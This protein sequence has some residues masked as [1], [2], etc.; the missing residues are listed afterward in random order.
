M[1]KKNFYLAQIGDQEQHV[2]IYDLPY[3]MFDAENP[4][5]IKKDVI[6]TNHNNTTNLDN[7]RII[8]SFDISKTKQSV[9]MPRYVSGAFI[10][11]GKPDLFDENFVFPDGVTEIDCAH[12]VKDLSYFIN[13][14]PNT[15][16]KIIVS[17]STLTSLQTDTELRAAAIS[18][19]QTYPD[20]QVINEKTSAKNLK[21]CLAQT[22]QK[23]TPQE[24]KQK[25]ITATIQEPVIL[26]KTSE[27]RDIKDIENV[28]NTNEFIISLNL[29]EGILNREIRKFMKEFDKQKRKNPAT[30]AQVTCIPAKN[31]DKLMEKVVSE[32][33]NKTEKEDNKNTP[34]A[35]ETK[36][37]KTV[38]KAEKKVL[39]TIKTKAYISNRLWKKLCGLCATDDTKRFV[40]ETINSVNLDPTKTDGEKLQ[41]I[42]DDQKVQSS[43]LKRNGGNCVV[44]GIDRL[45]KDRRRIIWTYFPKQRYFVCVD[46]V[47]EHFCNTGSNKAQIHYNNICEYA[48]KNQ[49]AKGHT[50]NIDDL[51]AYI[52][53]ADLLKEL[54][55]AKTEKEANVSKQKTST[56]TVP[57]KPAP[58]IPDANVLQNEETLSAEPVK[59]KRGRPRI[60]KPV[61]ELVSRG[62]RKKA[63]KESTDS[64]T[65]QS[66]ASEKI[67][68]KEA[69]AKILEN[70]PEEKPEVHVPQNEQPAAPVKK[71]RGRPRKNP[72]QPVVA[73]DSDKQTHENVA[74]FEEVKG[75]FEP[76][77]QIANEILV[78]SEPT[79]VKGDQ[80]AVLPKEPENITDI[81]P[82]EK[83]TNLADVNLLQAEIMS[84]IKT[85]DKT[86]QAGLKSVAQE[87]D[88]VKQLE[89]IDNI[90]ATLIQKEKLEKMLIEFEKTDAL[91]KKIQI[92]TNLHTK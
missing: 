73:S 77:E 46:V 18:F 16:R 22:Q 36:T 7:V 39:P 38:V 65:K 66:V 5:I 32:F 12:S 33:K 23:K 8:G 79:P 20:I 13:R 78:K 48:A 45:S 57:E 42:A 50:I 88:S 44:Q 84:F 51:S 62:Y 85:I 81:M 31:V 76:Q 4:L 43:Y 1:A 92:T 19:V 86:I 80:P 11:R 24:P 63:P 67:E 70:V 2:N 30:G 26:E 28:L 40:L 75:A 3:D 49:D 69:G 35:S 58:Q 56:K 68:V 74:D 91:L 29:K 17:N 82:I 60:K 25:T 89:Q 41:C 90:R 10:C 54:S 37:K 6:L 53:V 59:K 27:F 14:L 21:E 83:P 34:V 9:V 64:E 61:I 71:K 72:L 52:A 87:S 15:V 47:K 55:K